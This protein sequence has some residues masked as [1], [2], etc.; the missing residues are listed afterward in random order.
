MRN[1]WVCSLTREGLSGALQVCGGAGES[2]G[3]Y[4]NIDAD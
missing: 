4:W 3:L 1:R 2:G